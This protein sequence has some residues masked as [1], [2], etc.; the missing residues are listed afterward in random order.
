MKPLPPVKSQD[1]LPVTFHLAIIK[2]PDKSG[3]H[4]IVLTKMRGDEVLARVAVPPAS[5]SVDAALD[6][7]NKIATRVFYFGEGEEYL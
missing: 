2:D 7:F 4:S 1:K 3:M 6:D 5:E